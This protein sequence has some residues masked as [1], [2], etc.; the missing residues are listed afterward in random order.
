MAAAAAAAEFFGGGSSTSGVDD[1]V[2]DNGH[3]VMTHEVVARI[4]REAGGYRCPAVN[5]KMWLHNRRWKAIQNL[6]K[7]TGVAMLHLENNQIGPDIGP[8]LAHMRKLKA[9]YLN[10]NM[11]RRVDANLAANEQLSHLNLATNQIGRFEPGGLPASLNTVLVAANCLET[12]AAIEPLALLP[13]LEVLDLQ[14][15]RLDGDDLFDLFAR[16]RSLRVLYLMGNPIQR[17]EYYRKRLVSRCLQLTY[18]DTSPVE[19]LEK[20]GAEAWARGGRD[21][22][23][24]ARK[25]FVDDKR[26]AQRATTRRIAAERAARRAAANLQ[27]TGH[28]TT[29]D[30]RR[31]LTKD[32]VA[33]LPTAEL[34]EDWATALEEDECPVCQA[35]LRVG[36]RALPLEACGH[37]F[38]L[39]CLAPWLTQAS[40]TCPLCRAEVKPTAEGAARAATGAAA[41]AAE[42]K[43]EAAVMVE[44][45]E[46]ETARPGWGGHVQVGG[47]AVE[48]RGAAAAALELSRSRQALE[49]SQALA[50]RGTAGG[51][52]GATRV[53]DGQVDE[54]AFVGPGVGLAVGLDAGTVAA[55]P[56]RWIRAPGSNYVLSMPSVGA[57][58]SPGGTLSGNDYSNGVSS[59]EGGEVIL[60]GAEEGEDGEGVK[61]ADGGESAPQDDGEE[62]LPT[63]TEGQ[64][65]TNRMI[66]L[67][68]R[69]RFS[70]LSTGRAAI[71]ADQFYSTAMFAKLKERRAMEAAGGSRIDAPVVPSSSSERG[72]ERSATVKAEVTRD[73]DAGVKMPTTQAAEDVE[74]DGDSGG[75]GSV[76]HDASSLDEMGMSADQRIAFAA[77]IAGVGARTTSE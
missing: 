31:V 55:V 64:K 44:G 61:D 42:A 56:C 23:L 8:G 40:A 41:T 65:E 62:R 2:D 60:E 16:C 74:R 30:S 5:E 46:H 39:G 36:E 11:L 76:S 66:Q 9:L 73:G 17:A 13:N 77:K 59:G 48:V 18:L 43:S 33:M 50:Q 38:H 22:E 35:A 32:M 37:V 51:Q 68:L 3:P 21:A 29:G 52:G 26:A 57:T 1:P 53:R 10:C 24:L 45:G 12:A 4:V 28:G 7:Y 14:N 47:R 69:R 25:K 27:R 75:T 20:A 15:N 70:Q 63:Y 58:P 71:E 49:V 72:G 19:E 67:Q 34:T 54:G 6:G